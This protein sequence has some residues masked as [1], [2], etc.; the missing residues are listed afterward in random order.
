MDLEGIILSK[1]KS[2]REKQTLSVRT[3]CG[4]Q[5]IKE[6]IPKQK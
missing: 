6:S 3:S 5:N 4:L 2:E 1:V